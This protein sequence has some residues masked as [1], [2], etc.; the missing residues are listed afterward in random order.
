MPKKWENPIICIYKTSNDE[1]M[2]K[3]RLASC[4]RKALK[5]NEFQ[6]YYQPQY[7]QKQGRYMALRHL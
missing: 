4:L 6:L 5:N 2:E 7:I 3:V 1:I